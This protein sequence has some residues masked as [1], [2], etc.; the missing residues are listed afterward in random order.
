MIGWSLGLLAVACVLVLLLRLVRGKCFSL[1]P[2]WNVEAGS[3]ALHPGPVMAGSLSWQTLFPIWNMQFW[4]L[5]FLFGIWNLHCG[6]LRW[7]A[8]VHS[9]LTVM[10]GKDNSSWP[11]RGRIGK[12]YYSGMLAKKIHRYL[13]EKNSKL[14]SRFCKWNILFLKKNH[15]QY[16]RFSKSSL[17]H[18]LSQGHSS[19]SDILKGISCVDTVRV[20]HCENQREAYW[21]CGCDFSSK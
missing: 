18:E 3:S 16:F 8:D 2:L 13:R 12:D 20:R 10:A 19:E 17:I 7:V 15:I 11:L 1:R 9:S 14:G 6:M 5:N 4:I 21:A